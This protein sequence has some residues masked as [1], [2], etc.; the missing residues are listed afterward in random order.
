MVVLRWLGCALLLGLF[1]TGKTPASS[2]SGEQ[3]EE[4]VS[5]PRWEY[6]VIKLDAARCA[7]EG[8]LSGAMN[9]VGRKGWELVNY[10]H[11]MLFPK[12]L[13]G[14]MLI[15]PAATGPGKKNNPETT[16]SFKGDLTIKAP[17]NQNGDCR[18]LFK[19]PARPPQ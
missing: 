4:A 7:N 5:G 3:K 17:P 18:L 14:S 8:A 16:D 6:E 11:L 12:E 10:E 13:Q 1:V 2:Q 15:V 19:R 9:D